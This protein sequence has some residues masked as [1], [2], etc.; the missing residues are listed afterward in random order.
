[1]DVYE[2]P[3]RDLLLAAD[4]DPDDILEGERWTVRVSGE[5]VTLTRHRDPVVDTTPRVAA[6][7]GVGVR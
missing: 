4:I 5:S 7:G 2:L 1:M 3:L 6:V